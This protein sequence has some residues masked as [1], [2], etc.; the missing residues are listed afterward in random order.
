[1]NYNNHCINQFFIK[2]NKI[3]LFFNIPWQILATPRGTPRGAPNGSG[4][5]GVI[6]CMTPTPRGS[7]KKGKN[8][9]RPDPLRSLLFNII[10]I[11]LLL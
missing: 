4:R 6:V 1:M 2:E 7:G 10:N 9:T 5:V 11:F 8:P 3:L